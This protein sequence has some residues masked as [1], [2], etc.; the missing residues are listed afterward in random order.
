MNCP[1]CGTENPPDVTTCR[2]CTTELPSVSMTMTTGVASGWSASAPGVSSGVYRSSFVVFEPG[3]VIGNRY[4][5]LSLLGEG[6]MG[7]VYKVR[8]RELDRFVALKVIRPELAVRPEILQRFKQELILARQ[9]THKNVIRIFD[10]GEAEGVK[11][12]T[13]DF[14]E[15]KDLKALLYERGKF[16]AEESVK[17]M[18]Q[19]CR[20]LEA[21]HSEGVVHR[22]LKPQNIMVDSQERVTVMD[23][24]IARSIE[25][26]G[27]T[28]T[29][30]VIGTPEYM[31]P[32]Q[33]MGEHVDARSDLFTAGIIFY[34]L[35][36]GDTPFRADTAYAMLLKRT[37]RKARPPIELDPSIPQQINDV[38]VKC[39][40]MAPDQRYESASEILEDLGLKTFTGTRMRPVTVGAPTATVA[41]VPTAGF[42]QRYWKLIA[43]GATALLLVLVGVIFH[44]KIFSGGGKGEVAPS[45]AVA[46]VPFQNASG[47]SS[48]DWLGTS[49]AELLRTDV[50]ESSTLHPVSPDRLSHIL[51]DL[52]FNP[53]TELGPSELHR[54]AEFTSANLLV[55]GQYSKN[56]NQIR[57][58]AKIEDVK[59]NRTTSLKAEAT[60]ESTLLAAVDQ[61]ADSVR[62]GLAPDQSA[63]QEM[64][65]AAFR[66]TSNSLEAVRDF[67]TGLGFFR[68]RNHS[69][70]AK[71]FEAATQADPNFALAYSWL[72]RTYAQ[73]GNNEQAEQA[74]GK[75]MSLSGN[76]SPVE[77]YMIQAAYGQ[78]GNNHTKAVEAY[79]KLATLMPNDPQIH[80]EFGEINKSYGAYDKAQ[81]QYLKA[82]EIDPK[83]LE[84]L[85][86]L[87]EVEIELG[88]AQGAID[89]LNRAHSLAVELN[90]KQGTAI[91]LH[92]L[93]EAYNLLNRPDD[94][95]RNFQQ[96]LDIRREI[97]DKIGMA[98]TLDQIALTDGNIGK[99]REAEKTYQEELKLRSDIGDKA[100]SGNALTNFGLMLSQEGR[101]EEALTNTKQ[102]LQIEM[103][104]N[105]EPGQALSL[106][107]IGLFSFQLAK[108]DDALT[109]QQRAVDLFQKLKKP[110]ETALSLN[111]IGQTYATVGQ[112]DQAASSYTLGLEQARK[113][114]DKFTISGILD[115][116]ASLYLIQGRYGEALKSQ[117]EA[118]N[119]AKQL[120]AESGAF[121]AEVNADYANVLNQVGR[122]EEAQKILN[123]SLNFAQS[124]Q[125]EYLAAKILNFQG[126]GFYYRGDFKSAQPLFE[127]AQQSASKAKDLLQS[128]NARLNLA[129]TSVS[130]GHSAAAVGTL[131]GLVKEAETLGAKYIATQCSITLAEALLGTKDYT[132]AREELESTLRKSED[133]GMKSLEPRAHYLL[134]QVLRAGGNTVEA[135]MQLKLASDLLEQMRQESHADTL[136]ERSDLKPIVDATHK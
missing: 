43:G 133:S 99:L 32:E 28:Q 40:E 85:R 64:K 109:Y 26:P 22:D 80:Y 102:A 8:D 103:Q 130:E 18:A 124:A 27:M 108:Y 110:I 36:T 4:E 97:G 105:N 59:R 31:S 34:E 74:V 39:L 12:I 114:G 2:K 117:Q 29:G 81:E 77:K 53:N 104:T 126:E 122:A 129:R 111:N 134:S 1:Q 19:V 6:G 51:S 47:D 132:H 52:P 68:Q 135:D 24:G 100:G 7:A 13:M 76:L 38:V 72:G 92:D 25:M 5:V 65:A 69:E 115:G 50:G 23:F 42:M 67:T 58:D 57:I 88:N 55:W 71:Q 21:A 78:I 44:Q 96:S 56:G 127:R 37:T 87:G 11:F 113:I 123:E 94:A 60:G 62:A 66:P 89:H 91:V 41:E 131:K 106:M 9:V 16:S 118:V 73:L 86:G 95:L 101:Y 17:I 30:A 79:A 112:F 116:L 49:L 10:L 63:A 3:N 45:N 98:D 15:G 14:I 46:I 61:L 70:A 83:D 82:L 33:A 107:N 48:L 54:I 20:A 136:L 121:V 75:A 90:N 119:N 93:G 125:N 120:Q 128:L 35:L 84:S